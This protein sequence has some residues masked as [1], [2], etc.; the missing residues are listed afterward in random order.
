MYRWEDKARVERARRVNL[1][2][3]EVAILLKEEDNLVDGLSKRDL[4]EVDGE[5]SV[6]GS[7][8]GIVDASKVLDLTLAS[9]L[10]NTI[11][12]ALL[13]DLQGRRDMHEVETTRLLNHLAGVLARLVV[14][15]NGSHDGSRTSAGQLTGNE[16]LAGNVDVTVALGETELRGQLGTDV[17]AHEERDR[18]R[19]LLVERDLEGTGKGVLARGVQTGEEDGEALLSAGRVGLAEDLD[20]LG[21]GEPLGNGETRAQAAAELGTAD[22]EGLGA[23]RDLVGRHVLVGLGDVGHHLEGHNLDTDLILVLLDKLLGVVGAVE[24]DTLRVLTRTGVVTADD[25]VGHTVVLTDQRVPDSL[26]GTTH[27]H[28]QG[29]KAQ[30]GHTVGIL[31][32]EGLVDTHTGI[33]INVTGL[34][35]THDGVDQQVGLAGAGST[36]SQLTM[37]TVHGVASLEGDNTGPLQL[38]EVGAKFAGGN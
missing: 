38:L 6:S 21:V 23:L 22:V 15:S 9:T 33:V 35:Q 5:L 14:G 3:A 13:A 18:A 24:V 10:V 36:D 27:A 34:G 20:D 29:Q 31:G 16:G 32:H 11:V 30:L 4:A 12:I 37:S 28:G 8:I 1:S 7:L 25:E 2:R 19:A 26:T 17:F